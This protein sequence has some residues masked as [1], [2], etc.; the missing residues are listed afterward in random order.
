MCKEM[1]T[2][3]ASLSASGKSKRRLYGQSCGKLRVNPTSLAEHVR[4][5]LKRHPYVFLSTDAVDRTTVDCL[6][7]FESLSDK[8][9]D[10]F[11]TK[12]PKTPPPHGYHLGN[13]VLFVDSKDPKQITTAISFIGSRG[14]SAADDERGRR[15]LSLCNHV[16][17]RVAQGNESMYVC[18]G[19]FYAYRQRSNR[20]RIGINL[21]S[22]S[23][24]L[25]KKVLTLRY[26]GSMALPED[27]DIVKYAAPHVKSLVRKTLH[28]KP[29]PS[30]SA[31][32]SCK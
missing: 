4:S 21:Y 28:S 7:V 9:W 27:G 29:S 22:G 15:H 20:L 17:D 31:A 12:K 6:P 11:D 13:W 26:F 23:M 2:F 19:T 24:A 16:R 10:R 8:T 25:A 5:S 3:V 18:S 14:D 32:A 1:N 30:P